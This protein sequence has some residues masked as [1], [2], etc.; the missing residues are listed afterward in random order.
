MFTAFMAFYLS[1]SVISLTVAT[2]I[3]FTAPFFITLLSIPILG[4]QVGVRRFVGILM[5]F[6][7]GLIVSRPDTGNLSLMVVLSIITALFY[8]CCQLMVRTGGNTEPISV[9]TLY[10][11]IAFVALGSLIGVIF[12]II[13][14]SLHASAGSHL[15]VQ[16][17]LLPHSRDWLYLILTGV[18]S[19]FV[20][21]LTS[22]AYRIGEASK[23][24]P[25]EYVMI[26]WVVI[27]SYLGWSEIPDFFYYPGNRDYR[28]FASL[29]A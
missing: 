27:L 25:F 15:L 16:S 14:P 4:E 12:S 20:F 7:G 17:W 5:G 6:F 3:F 24:A 9:M 1:L 13:E 29:C 2:A 19:G 22:G 23:L 21:M 28:A 8:A 11:S 26:I 10:A 18:T